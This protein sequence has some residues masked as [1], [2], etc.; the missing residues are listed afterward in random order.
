MDAMPILVRNIRQELKASQDALVEGVARR[1]K[2][3]REAVGCYAVVR[4]SVDAR[5]RGEVYYS[6]NVQLA[7]RDVEEERRVVRR[8]HRA[9]VQMLRP[10]PAPE[11]RIGAEPAPG[12]PVVVGFGPAGMFASLLLAE[13]GYRPLVLERGQDVSS[14]HRDVIQGFYGQGRFNPESNL[15]YGEGGAGTYSDGKLYT[16]LN[17]RRVEFV[18]QTF[19]RHGA[20]PAVLI[21]GKPHVGSE[22]LPGIAR[23]LRLYIESLGGEVRF[24]RR[25]NGLETVD[26]RLRSVCLDGE[27]IEAQIC[28]WGTGHSARDTYRLLAAHG[29]T[30]V[31]KPYQMGLRIEHPQDMVNK[32]HA[33]PC[34]RPSISWWPKEP[35][36]PATMCLASACA[37]GE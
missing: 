15:L 32:W 7:L 19:F 31:P 30:L 9:D 10:A 34:P 21:D 2:V 17:D 18:L 26:H 20:K 11:L 36:P 8:L 29:A 35:G 33:A 22:K 6:C 23:R 25:V 4:R 1:L 13:H 37:R 3:P 5:R 27:R 14:R 28:I 12:R 24:G 16:R